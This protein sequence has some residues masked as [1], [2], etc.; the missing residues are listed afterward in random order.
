MPG[1]IMAAC[2]I[3]WSPLSGR[4][5]RGVVLEAPNCRALTR[6][7]VIGSALDARQPRSSHIHCGESGC[8]LGVQSGTG[9]HKVASVL[10]IPKFAQRS[11]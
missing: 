8:E 4:E 10:S 11:L 9:S 3:P 2:S 5:E 6:R 1:R 7:R